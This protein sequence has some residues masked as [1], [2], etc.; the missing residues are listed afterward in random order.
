MTARH[1]LAISACALILSAG[2]AN[3]GPCNTSQ[4]TG[5]GAGQQ[6]ANRAAQVGQRQEHAQPRVAQQPQSTGKAE[7][8]NSTEQSAVP[9]AKMTDQ[10]QS[11]ATPS[12]GSETSTK[13]ADQGC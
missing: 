1:Q 10:D 6:A 13:M 9:S 3:A 4:T 11:S 5:T 7:Q 2:I 8:P 12:Q